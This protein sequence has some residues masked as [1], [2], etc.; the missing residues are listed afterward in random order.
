M[1]CEILNFF[2]TTGW[3]NL[4]FFSGKRCTKLAILFHGRSMKFEIFSRLTD[5][6]IFFSS[7]WQ[8]LRGFSPPTTDWWNLRSFLCNLLMGFFCKCLTK[9]VIFAGV[10]EQNLNFYSWNIWLNFF[11]F[12]SCC[13]STNFSFQLSGNF[14]PADVPVHFQ[15]TEFYPVDKKLAPME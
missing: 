1:F 15:K 10:I 9:V 6:I 2:S 3:R 4:P 14:S 13:T 8:N 5:K 7:N 12:F 11:F